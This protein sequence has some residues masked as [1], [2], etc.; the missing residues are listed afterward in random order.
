[1]RKSVLTTTSS[2]NAELPDII[3]IL[4]R[5]DLQVVQNPHG[6]RVNEEEL[7]MLLEKYRPVGLLAGTEPITGR[8]LDKAKGYLRVI[9]RVGAG[10]D[11]V[12]KK[13]AAGF[14]IAVYRTVGILT[15]SVAELAVGMILAALRLFTNYDRQLRCGHWEKRMGGLLQGKLLGIVGFGAIGQRVG[16]LAKAFGAEVIFSD[17]CPISVDWAREEQLESLLRCADVITLHASGND[18]ILGANELQHQ[19]K[20]GVII[21]NTARGGLIDESALMGCL[22]SGQVGYA[23]LDVFEEEPYHGPL[24]A[25]ENVILTPHIG[26]YASEARQR[27]ETMAVENLLSG[28]REAGILGGELI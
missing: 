28:L 2:F 16:E 27:M 1:M 23:C 24:C 5:Y 25:L 20:R 14:G 26:S 21:V 8:L 7:E 22:E 9:S 18:V 15:E 11:N 17:P 19:C 10:W 12:D 6:R 4:K 3:N 13:A